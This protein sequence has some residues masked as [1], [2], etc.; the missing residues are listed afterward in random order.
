MHGRS[1]CY[2]FPF[3]YM[4]CYISCWY[5]TCLWG[6][7]YQIHESILV[8]TLLFDASCVSPY[9]R[10]CHC[11][12]GDP[13]SAACHQAKM[14]KAPKDCE[15]DMALLDVCISDRRS[16]LPFALSDLPSNAAATALIGFKVRRVTAA[17]QGRMGKRL[18][19]IKV[20]SRPAMEM[21]ARLADHVLSVSLSVIPLNLHTTQKPE[22]F[23]Q[24]TMPDPHPMARKT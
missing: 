24:E 21:T 10:H 13:Y 1:A 14:G 17:H 9:S 18:D 7:A 19:A 12:D 3:P 23:I 16:D 22:S 15:M 20:S 8:Q 2:L 11:S 6:C 5:A 4:L